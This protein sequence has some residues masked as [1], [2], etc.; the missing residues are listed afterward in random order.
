MPG[1]FQRE[2]GRSFLK[3][4]G[5]AGNG[6]VPE[7]GSRQSLFQGTDKGLYQGLDEVLLGNVILIDKGFLI[8]HVRPYRT[9]IKLMNGS[10][11]RKS[12]KFFVYRMN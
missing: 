3:I 10:S 2:P 6:R 1:T 9:F 4:R 7:I 5:N 12:N 11:N 8:E